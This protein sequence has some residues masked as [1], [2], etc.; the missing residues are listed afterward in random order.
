MSSGY[1]SRI[2]ELTREYCKVIL[3]RE[4]VLYNIRP[5][6]LLNE[7]TK[8]NLELDIYFENLKIGIEVNGYFHHNDEGTKIRDSIK[9]GLCVRRGIKLF[10]INRKQDLLGLRKVLGRELNIILPDIPKELNY[11]IKKYTNG[12]RFIR[13]L[14]FKKL[15]KKHKRGILQQQEETEGIKRRN[16]LKLNV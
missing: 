6:W 12:N 2:E 15:N 9:K 5:D 3:P 14:R 16:T 7:I 8:K 13:V 10:V 4:K 11:S 1:I